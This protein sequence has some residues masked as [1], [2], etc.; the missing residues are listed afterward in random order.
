MKMT[1]LLWLSSSGLS[2]LTREGREEHDVG[3]GPNGFE[4]KYLVS[5]GLDKYTRLIARM[6]VDIE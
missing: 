2:P 6:Y 5:G 1:L 4:S 3:A